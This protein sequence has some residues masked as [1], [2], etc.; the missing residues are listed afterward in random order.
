LEIK[1]Q[2]V[3]NDK[4]KKIAV[5]IDIDTFE[6][7]E[8]LLENHILMQMIKDSAEDKVYSIH[9]G[10]P[11]ILKNVMHEPPHLQWA[12]VDALEREIEKAKIPITQ[13]GAFD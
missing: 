7:I 13:K 2:F 4:N 5:Q 12:D 3:V 8:D 9:S 6:K 1:K 11:S 10:S